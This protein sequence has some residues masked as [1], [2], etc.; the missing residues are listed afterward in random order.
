MPSFKLFMPCYIRLGL[1]RSSSCHAFCYVSNLLCH[2]T[3]GWFWE[4]QIFMPCYFLCFKLLML[5]HFRLILGSSNQYS[6]ISEIKNFRCYAIS[7]WTEEDQIHAM[8]FALSQFSP[9]MPLQVCPEK[10]KFMLCYFLCLKLLMP[11]H[12]RLI[13]GKIKFKPC[14]FLCLNF[15]MP[16]HFRL[17]LGGSNSFHAKSYVSNFSC[18]VTSGRC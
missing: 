15:L 14:Y 10:I 5:C 16:C 8:P 2:A 17:V 18:H 1:E 13:L 9:A 12:F 11:C 7:S 4:D 6:A 3:S